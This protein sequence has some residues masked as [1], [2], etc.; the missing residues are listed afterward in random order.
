MMNAKQLISD[1]EQRLMTECHKSFPEATAVELHNAVS[2]AAMDAVAPVWKKKEDA[3][4]PRRQA[5]YLSMEYLVGRLVYNNLYC[6]GMLDD[7]R[8]LLKDK[9]VD[10]AVMEDVEDDAFGNG[11]LGRL[12]ACFL[13]SAVTCDVPLTGYGLRFRYGL[14]KQRF[15]DGR[16]VEEPDDWAKFG[17]PWSIRRPDE[18]VLVP[19]KSGDVLAVP[20]DM[21]V[22]GYGAKNVGTLRLW[23]TESPREVDFALFNRQDYAKAAAA[24]NQAED[25]TKFLYPN[26]TRKEGRQLRV[27]QQYVLVSATMQDILRAYRKRHGSDYSFFAKE[28]SAQL[29]DTHPTMAIPE[30]IRLL[31]EDSIP[32]EDA[33]LIARDTFAYTNHTVMQEA[34]EKWDLPL[35]NSVCPQIVPVIR[36]IDARFRKEMKALGKE[37]TPSLCIILDGRVHMASLAVYSTHATNGVAEL[38]SEILKNDV[39]ADWYRIW[40]ER[41]QNKTN[42]ITQR[43]W[44]GLCNPELCALIE[45]KIGP[46]FITDLDRLHELKPMVNNALA[47]KFIAVKK[48]KKKQLC[49]E[50][51]R[52]EGIVLDPSMV[53]DVQI[54]R[55]HEYK[56]Q[57]MNALC[58]TAIYDQIRR[59]QLKDLPPVAFIF[60]AKAA[61][62][63][64]R[65]KAVI[66]WIN[67]L[68]EK[69]NNDP[70]AKDRLKI[71]FVQNYNCSW[72]EKIIPA[73]DISEQISPAGTEAS[74]TGNMKLMLN[75]AVT[76]GTF[77]GA[78]VEIV[79][80]AGLENNYIFGAT[81]E[82]LEKIK[83]TYDPNRIY[84]KNALLRRSL[85]TL[86]DG[87]FPDEDGMLKELHDAILKG[88][89]W[90]KPD[91]YY[92]MKDFDSYYKTRLQAIKDA[93]A[94]EVAF[95]RK[96]LMNVASA[97]K[98]S[99]DRTIRQYAK[100]IWNV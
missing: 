40:P 82:E 14:F 4:F 29:N 99:S 33:F 53:F 64:D 44:L 23:Q 15:V 73:A 16:Q 90:H 32:F 65:A 5:F 84:A 54:K 91:H 75:G 3:R 39:F 67:M 80:E 63:Y 97:G 13:D 58:I 25:I 61:P 48:E 31:G 88:A 30:L 69:V 28:V 18:A 12:A 100:D 56:R 52:R 72:A 94:D 74:G 37:I 17:D 86:I 46:G 76:L 6:M 36:K 50:I 47:K 55:L 43:R 11:G 57:F 70:K 1:A 62:G 41:F 19:L 77:D 68:A 49:A 51:L 60:G 9:G 98:F 26:D 87:T 92:V 59:G 27:R 83:A 10:I 78:N 95:A 2:G 21:P 45:G 96:C 89:S 81:V 38:H 79:E 7:V 22:I 42:G 71:I 93:K 20:Y 66:H 34:L 35:L 85:D 8:S 24:K